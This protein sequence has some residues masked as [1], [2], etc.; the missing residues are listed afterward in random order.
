MINNYRGEMRNSRWW[1]RN[2]ILGDEVSGAK[3][4]L[5]SLHMQGA[6]SAANPNDWM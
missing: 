4:Q 2:C 6:V 1:P 3:Q 5:V